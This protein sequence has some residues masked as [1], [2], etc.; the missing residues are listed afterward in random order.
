MSATS[1]TAMRTPQPK[2][3]R[4][5]PWSDGPGGGG[6]PL[7]APVPV[8]PPISPWTQGAAEGAS[9]TL[10]S[11]TAASAPRGIRALLAAV[12]LLGLAWGCLLLLGGDGGLAA[13]TMTMPKPMAM[14]KP[15]GR[16]ARREAA[17]TEAAR[18]AGER[19]RRTRPPPPPPPAAADGDGEEEGVGRSL[20][21]SVWPRGHA[22]TEERRGGGGALGGRRERIQKGNDGRG[23]ASGRRDGHGHGDGPGRRDGDGKGDA[24]LLP[25]PT[26]ALCGIHAQ[27]AAEDRPGS[28][29]V[30]DALGPRSR[31]LL[32]GVLGPVGYHLALA[33]SEQCGVRVLVGMDPML[34]NS[35][36]HR[37][38]LARRMALLQAEVGSG[39]VRPLLLPVAGVDQPPSRGRDGH[40][41]LGATGEGDLVARHRPTHVVHLAAG[42]DPN[43]Y[44]DVVGARGGMQNDASAYVADRVEGGS[45]SGGG[46]GSRGGARIP[47]LFQLRQ[48]SSSMEHLLAS[49]RGV[50][51]DGVDGAGG[52]RQRR[53]PHLLYASAPPPD[54]SDL[55]DSGG[56]GG[57]PRDVLLE[58]GEVYR[59][60]AGAVDEL[61]AATYHK[62]DGIYSVG[63]RFPTVYGPWGREGN[64]DYD[65][66]A[67]AAAR[68]RRPNLTDV[69]RNDDGRNDD[70]GG[71]A[72]QLLNATGLLG[73]ASDAERSVLFV[74]DAVEAI[75][76]AMQYRRE[77]DEPVVFTAR[78]G[79]RTTWAAFARTVAVHASALIRGAYDARGGDAL[80]QRLSGGG[81]LRDSTGWA[82]RTCLKEG[83]LKLLGWH[84]ERSAP[85]GDESGGAIPLGPSE[86]SEVGVSPQNETKW[87]R[88]RGKRELPCASECKPSP[89]RCSESV[90]DSIV[91]LTKG[92][93]RG[94]GL[95]FYSSTWDLNATDVPFEVTY[96]APSNSSVPAVCNLMFVPEESPF[97]GSLLSSAGKRVEKDLKI[98]QETSMRERMEVLNGRLLYRG[99]IVIWVPSPPL[100]VAAD[101][102]SLL[103]LSPGRFF[104]STAK[105][106]IYASGNY[107]DPLGFDQV[108]FLSTLVSRKA[109]TETGFIKGPPKIKLPDDVKRHAILGAP[110]MLH[111]IL[112]SNVTVG[113]PKPNIK[114][115]TAVKVM[116]IEAATDEAEEVA[117]PSSLRRQREFYQ[118]VASTLD[119]KEIRSEYEPNY[120]YSAS[121]W[122][123]GNTL[124][125]DLTTE[126]A[127][128]LR[129]EWY[130]EHTLW[131]N[132]HDQ[133]SFAHVMALRELELRQ[134][135][136]DADAAQAHI[137]SSS[138]TPTQRS[139]ELLIEESVDWREWR[140]LAS[141]R[142]RRE[143]L[144]V[145]PPSVEDVIDSMLGMRPP[146]ERDASE[147]EYSVRIFRP[148]ATAGA[149]RAIL[150]ETFSRLPGTQTSESFLRGERRIYSVRKLTQ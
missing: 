55:V 29:Q 47:P 115:S 76:A 84:L 108:L 63:L 132:D 96:P 54:P 138:M 7:P 101:L 144:S 140:P 68:L 88:M 34:P 22:L 8:P 72:R 81:R 20:P 118:F 69:D 73:P 41:V 149:R 13:M 102:R 17:R 116:L 44:R 131:G 71:E 1:P 79:E 82:P 10:A 3:R 114:M 32:T 103:K 60:T 2:R 14:P 91:P 141:E 21:A 5:A 57:G 119:R 148:D 56:G 104:S 120:L 112:L 66:A 124:V 109:S 36:G 110:I 147:V 150:R 24:G 61:L 38:G 107:S 45:S 95:I 134:L 11:A 58:E 18:R 105:Q 127:R 46:G 39:L 86:M 33:L 67:A 126:E 28:Y 9:S 100:P 74:D 78:S 142:E 50:P 123:R 128:Q 35:L 43:A 48:A 98:G 83:I 133:L 77:G 99:W 25:A 15:S 130:E 92:I 87:N 40:P 146:P 85:Y 113:G 6:K 42:A 135:R 64:P 94:C 117:E 4:G 129:C 143:G 49:I 59:R 111:P 12:A 89:A 145:P 121:H 16:E 65:L 52:G 53:R 139:T 19:R 80:E 30:R 27:R 23:T 97:V 125:H 51:E 75:I 26:G 136:L 62:T 106:A 90:Y 93:S 70:D 137:R 122:I 37:A 31:V